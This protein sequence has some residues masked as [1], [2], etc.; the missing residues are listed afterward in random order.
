[1]NSVLISLILTWCAGAKV[2]GPPVVNLPTPEVVCRQKLLKCVEDH[3][4]LTNTLPNECLK[5][6]M[7][8]RQ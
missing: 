6:S 1:M 4:D 2:Q 7:E 3:P 5:D 8:V